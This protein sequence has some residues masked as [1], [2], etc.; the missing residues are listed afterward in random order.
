MAWPSVLTAAGRSARELSLPALRR[1]FEQRHKDGLDVLPF[2]NGSEAQL[3]SQLTTQFQ[4]E[5]KPDMSGDRRG[6]RSTGDS[7]PCRDFWCKGARE[8]ALQCGGKREFRLRVT[9]NG[10]SL[11]TPLHRWQK[12]QQRPLPSFQV[13]SPLP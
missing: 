9:E 12:A 7:Q 5:E 4:G 1:R 2:L 8:V 10:S 11:S 3:L 6:L 13:I